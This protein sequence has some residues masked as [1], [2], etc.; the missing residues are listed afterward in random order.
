MA[1]TITY[2]QNLSNPSSSSNPGFYNGSGNP[3]GGWTTVT[4]SSGDIDFSAR[5]KYRQDPNVI[6]TST[7]I[8]QVDPGFQDATHAK[9]NLE[10]SFNGGI[11]GVPAVHIADVLPF[12]TVTISDLTAGTST[13]K[14]LD[15]IWGDDSTWG[16]TGEGVLSPT[17]LLSDW[18]FQNSENPKFGDFPNGGASFDPN[19]Q[20]FYKVAFNINN[21]LGNLLTDT[22][23]IK[24]GDAVNPAPEASS[25][26]M[27]A[28]G[29]SLFGLGFLRRKQRKLA[30]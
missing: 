18:G 10:F 9:W 25:I 30:A 22:I 13:T 14:Y 11:G 8:Y 4:D 19:A 17:T 6:H 28:G 29:L 3:D 2:D 27:L 1:D 15:Q 24:V 7:N 23:Y 26:S 16:S 12:S 20:H 5:V 21:A